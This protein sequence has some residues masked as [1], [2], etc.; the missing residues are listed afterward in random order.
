MIEHIAR[1]PR[2]HDR[3]IFIGEAEDIVPGRFGPELLAIRDWTEQ[4]FRF[5][6]YVTGSDGHRP[7]APTDV[8]RQPGYPAR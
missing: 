2:V 8:R 6:G 5:A 7:A 1:C 4:Q 3:A